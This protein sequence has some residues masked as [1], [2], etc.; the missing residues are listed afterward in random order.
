M[1]GGNVPWRH[2]LAEARNEA[3]QQ[4]KLILIDLFSPH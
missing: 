3:R 1:A 4:G 2:S